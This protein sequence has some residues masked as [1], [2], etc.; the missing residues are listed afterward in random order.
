MVLA[1]LVEGPGD[2]TLLWRQPRVEVDSVAALQMDAD[3]R[4]VG[5][6]LKPLCPQPGHLQQH[7]GLRDERACIGEAEDWAKCAK[8]TASVTAVARFSC[9]GAPF[10]KIS[11]KQVMSA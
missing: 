11:K 8:R 9:R 3:E 10:K 1:R 6:P 7:R 2:A 4:G 5:A